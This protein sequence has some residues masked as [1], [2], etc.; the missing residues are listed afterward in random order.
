MKAHTKAPTSAP[1]KAPSNVHMNLHMKIL[2][3]KKFYFWEA[4]ACSLFTQEGSTVVWVR[5]RAVSSGDRVLETLLSFVYLDIID[6][7][8]NIISPKV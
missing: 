7:A 4:R 2:N 6:A 8:T 3:F 5:C 1:S